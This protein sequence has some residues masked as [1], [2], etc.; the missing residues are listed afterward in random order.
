[1]R[2]EIPHYALLEL[3]HLVLD[4]NGTIAFDGRLKAEVAAVMPALAEE[5]RIHVITADT[6]GTVAAQLEGLP[7][8]VKILTSDDHTSEK[9]EFVR[10][11]GAEGCVAVGNG[12]NDRAM[13][14]A[15]VLGIVI[16]GEEG[17]AV[18][19]LMAADLAST[20]I[21]EALDLL[22]EPKRLVA[23]LRK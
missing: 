3:E 2:I 11:L 18:P 19:T 13:L 21:G 16:L 6:F 14:E 23:T 15:A 22:L 4:Y 10:S 12:N 17:C 20:S 9:A 8:E 1:M 7:A 5:L